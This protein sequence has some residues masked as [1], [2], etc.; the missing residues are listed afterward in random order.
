MLIYICI[1]NRFDRT[2]QKMKGIIT[3]NRDPTYRKKQKMKGIITLNRD[4]TYRKKQNMKG[5]ITLNRDPTYRKQT[6]Y[7]RHNNLEL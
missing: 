6:K 1:T 5:I 3:L 2:N 4:P 7:E